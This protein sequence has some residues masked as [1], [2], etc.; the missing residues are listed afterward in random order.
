MR[1]S[2]LSRSVVLLTLGAVVGGLLTASWKLPLHAQQQT[3]TT[4]ATVVADVTHLRD[5]VPPSSHPMVDVGYH[6]V[7]LWFAAQAKNWPLA[8]Y[9]LG[10]TRNRLRWE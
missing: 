9:Y 5:I 7:N 8:N 1:T 6:M 4:E 2:R 3:P 10:E